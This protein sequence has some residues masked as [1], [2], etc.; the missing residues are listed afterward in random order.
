VSVRRPVGVSVD[1]DVW[2]E[3]AGTA[4]DAVAGPSL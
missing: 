2:V 1:G 4:E 3:L